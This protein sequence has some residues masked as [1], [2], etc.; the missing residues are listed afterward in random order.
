MEYLLRDVEPKVAL[1]FFEEISA[2]PR[3]SGNE[4][5]MA[6]YLVAFAKAH[7]LIFYRDAVNNVLIKAPATK[8]RENEPAII[9]QA[10][11]DMVAEKNAG[12]VHDFEKEGVRLV[13][14]GDILHA[15]GTTL[16]ADDG[17]GVS[18]I[19]GV[20]TEC[21]NHPALE[22]L[23]TSSEETGMDGALA[24]DY[25]QLSARVLLNLDGGEEDLLTCGCCGGLRSD[26]H[27]PVT[28]TEDTAQGLCITLDGLCGGH[29]GEDIHRGR[30]NALSL[31]AELLCAVK[32]LGE[33]RIAVLH[34]GDKSNAIPRDCKAVISVVDSARA[35]QVL[36]EKIAQIRA[37]L[38]A[39][40]AGFVASVTPCTASALCAAADTDRILHLLS[41]AGGVMEWHPEIEGLPYTS[42]NVASVRLGGG[43][44]LIVISHRSF[45]FAK[46]EESGDEIKARAESVNG[47]VHH[48]NAYPGWDSPVSSP[49]IEKWRGV[50]EEMTG[51][52]L[53]VNAIHAG[54]ECG[55]FAGNLPGLSAISLGV[56]IKDLHT[57]AE[58]M[59]LSSYERFYRVLLAFLKKS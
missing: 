32:E 21:E 28:V 39:D 26:L 34:G 5:G 18:M 46:V 30:A 41:I 25:T 11:T 51:T 40:D 13:R 54:L 44:C 55:L 36:E 37:G 47:W 35:A 19:L 45:D 14:A 38:V 29:S 17:Y 57:P 59:E 16:G 31:M 7:G 56:N 48:H 52:P 6:D 9:L 50:Y 20:L 22:C 1:R 15:D 23:F 58:R 24:F 3:A 53:R 10:H 42:R 43:E 4:G 12:V 33:L 2:I 49:L 27:L 8:G